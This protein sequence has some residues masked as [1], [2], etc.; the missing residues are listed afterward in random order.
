MN[1]DRLQQIEELYH[2]AQA[3]ELDR[4]AAFLAD[5]CGDDAELLREVESLL[6]Y[7]GG[8]GPL[9][10]PAWEGAGTFLELTVTQI[11]PGAQFGPYKIEAP[12]GAGGM[13]K[14]FRA[15]DTRLGRAVAIKVVD[16][17]FSERFE[18]E[19]R[20]IAALNHP[21][22]CTLYDVGPNYLVMEVCEGETLAARLKR[23]KLSIQ[24][25]LRYGA[26]IADALSA[27]HTKG[28][29]HRDLKPG[30]IMVAKSGVKV[31]DFGLAKSPHDA[32]MTATNMVMGT[33]AYMA[34]EQR[35]GK[36]CDARTDT[37][38]MGLVLYEMASGKRVE[39]GQMP[40]M[41][42]LPE[43]LAHVIERCTA[44]EPEDRWQSTADLCRE[45][46]W[47]KE[48]G[49]EAATA[50]LPAARGK[51]RERMAWGVAA[52]L[53]VGLIA[54]V[55]LHFRE[56]PPAPA[57]PLHLQVQL[58]EN[59]IAYPVLSPDGRKIAFLSG[60]SPRLWVHF[61]E[62]GESRD[63]A[64]AA[65]DTP[66]WSPDS[67]FIGYIS[68]GKI[69][70][71]EA[72][73]GHPQTVTDLHT[74][75]SWG[76]GAWSQDDVIVFGDQ[77]VGIVRV[78]ASGGI[79]VKITSVDFARNENFHFGPSFLPDGRHFLYLRS[80]SDEGK[81]AI[82]VGSL[83]AKPEQ[84]SSQ[85][86][87]ASN[88]QPKYAPSADPGTGYLL[89]TRGVTLM[90]QP[91]DNRRLELKGQAAPVA[92]QVKISSA[93]DT[94]GTHVA[95]AGHIDFSVSA[96][97]ALVVPRNNPSGGQLTWVDREGKVMGTV[98]EPANYFS[99]WA[100][101]PDGTQLAVSKFQE[102]NAA[103]LWLLDLSRSGVS[104]RFTFDSHADRDPVWSPDGSRIIFNSNRDGPYDLY[105]KPVNGE[106]DEEVL[107]KSG[108]NKTATSWS[109][110]GRFLLYTVRR[111]R[112]K[113]DVW[114]L[115]LGN[116]KKPFPFLSTEFNESQ[117]HFSPDGHW[118]AYTS[119]ESGQFEVYVRS[120]SMNPAGTAVEAGGKWQISNG[121]GA[122]T[123]WRGDG[124]ELYYRSLDGRH[125]AVEITTH[126][127][128]RA[129]PPHPV[130]PVT[131]ATW[132]V[133]AD[134]RRFLFISGAGGPA[135]YEMVLNWQ[136]GLK[137]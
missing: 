90:A 86:L 14:V 107:L 71:I 33:L 89:F 130:G 64:A 46:Q 1:R 48:R 131:V 75:T 24:E 134:G 4:R 127:A 27:A 103:N 62:S 56:E 45:L 96:N 38:S 98:G 80:S 8:N 30:N 52:A 104:T 70:K 16:E 126:P 57:A 102:G 82:Y 6:A 112:T 58:S 59:P 21:H 68:E 63:L 79:P 111:P 88:S 121:F 94:L 73:G 135:L 118:V 95:A 108:E 15:R 55:F 17:K 83:D 41:E 99:R 74:N 25:T 105:Q 53:T 137:K 51:L 29:V 40:P 44:Q 76:G 47:I 114:V 85:A 34:P 7:Q 23:G 9:D 124:R 39:Q 11:V 50:P 113:S 28:I 116:G 77:K 92:E 32:T 3:Q 84:Q 10:R 123:R 122:E 91:F 13:G 37:Y 132:D 119:D 61:L 100:L 129:G 87:V 81:S 125:M 97:G 72:D 136:A 65:G 26:Q 109:T 2:S 128:F 78:P 42:H 133:S 43:K 101:S 66:F 67:R 35:E 31:L 110:D 93:G 5:A 49:A 36:E 19:A 22:I 12:L 18:R 120:F 115:P 69:E 106:K 54:V 60:R 117:A 20:A